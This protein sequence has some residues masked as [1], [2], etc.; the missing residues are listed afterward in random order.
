MKKIEMSQNRISLLFFIVLFACVL[1]SN[2]QEYNPFDVRY[3]NNIK[4]DLTFIANNIVNRD[5][6]TT[7]GTPEDPYDLTGDSSNYNDRLD[8]QFIDKTMIRRHLVPVGQ[9]SPSRRPV[10]TWFAMRDSIGPLPTPV[11]RQEMRWARTDR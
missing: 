3:R 4:G 9:I 6:G 10:A 7:T 8:M 1:C 2:A 5:D 11:P